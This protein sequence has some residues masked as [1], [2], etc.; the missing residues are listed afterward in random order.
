MYQK[1]FFEELKK[2]SVQF[3]LSYDKGENEEVLKEL[4]KYKAK[5]LKM[6]NQNG[7]SRRNY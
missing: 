5:L 6:K 4:A 3:Y 2:V 1:E 7:I